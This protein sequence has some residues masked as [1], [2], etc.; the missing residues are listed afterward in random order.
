MRG[1]G[2]IQARVV[3]YALIQQY[4]ATWG[5]QVLHVFDRGYASGL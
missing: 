4:T 2:T 3:Q 1:Q 5:R